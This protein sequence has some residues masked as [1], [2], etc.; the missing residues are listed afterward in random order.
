MSSV[1]SSAPSTD[2]PALTNTRRYF[3]VTIHYLH[4]SRPSNKP[5][6]LFLPDV[7]QY[8]GKGDECCISSATAHRPVAGQRDARARLIAKGRLKVERANSRPAE[9]NKSAGG[10][11]P[12]CAS[13][14]HIK[15]ELAIPYRSPNETN[16]WRN[17][18]DGKR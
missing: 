6:R 1:R 5:C 3:I 7:W 4:S 8:R 10:P 13:A 9:N 16:P 2:R 12:L 18:G 11:R 15:G 17:R 14:P